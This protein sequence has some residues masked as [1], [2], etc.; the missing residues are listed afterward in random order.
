MGFWGIVVFKASWISVHR[1]APWFA[2]Q[3]RWFRSESFLCEIPNGWLRAR[4]PRKGPFGNLPFAGFAFWVKGRPAALSWYTNHEWACSPPRWSH[5]R[6]FGWCFGIRV[7]SLCLSRCWYI[8]ESYHWPRKTRASSAPWIWEYFGFSCFPHLAVFES[9]IPSLFSS[10]TE[11]RPFGLII[12][13]SG[14]SSWWN[15]RNHRGLNN[16]VCFYALFVTFRH[17]REWQA[18]LSIPLSSS[19][20]GSVYVT[21]PWN[22]GS[23]LSLLTL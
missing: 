14:S 4:T 11:T 1:P 18:L 16:T 10:E 23:H 15:L 22:H 2:C 12:Y 13:W 8:G 21:I 7:G 9:G 6:T 3:S 5:P 19:R 20:K 17:F